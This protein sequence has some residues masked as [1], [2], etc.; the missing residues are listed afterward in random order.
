MKIS[1]LGC[2][3]LIFLYHVLLVKVQELACIV[4]YGIKKTLIPNNRLLHL[5][6]GKIKHP[7][8]IENIP[9]A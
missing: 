2:F 1:F 4:R 7:E 5:F 9:L 6:M 8:S 3:I